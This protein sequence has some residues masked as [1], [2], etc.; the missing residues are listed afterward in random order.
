MRWWCHHHI[1]SGI[2]CFWGRRGPSKV[3]SVVTRWMRNQIPYPTSS[4]NQNLSKNTGIYVENT[5]KK[6]SFF[7]DKYVNSTIMVLIL[8]KFYW[9]LN[10]NSQKLILARFLIRPILDPKFPLM[11]IYIYIYTS[12]VNKSKYYL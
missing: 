11:I 7:N 12:T 9:F 8:C 4:P 10:S 2:N 5:N 6:S 1:F 3:C